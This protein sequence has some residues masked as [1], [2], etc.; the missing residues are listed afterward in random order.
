M[1]ALRKGFI[2]CINLLR[3]LVQGSFGIQVGVAGSSLIACCVRQFD[4][5]KHLINIRPAKDRQLEWA[6]RRLLYVARKSR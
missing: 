2:S 6:L 4:A 1:K 5:I 3:L